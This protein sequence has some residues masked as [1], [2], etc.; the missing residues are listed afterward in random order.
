MEQH[1]EAQEHPC[2]LTTKIGSVFNLVTYIYIFRSSYLSFCCSTASKY[3]QEPWNSSTRLM[4]SKQF[5]SC[6]WMCCVVSKSCSKTTMATKQ[7]REFDI[8][9]DSWS[10]G[11]STIGRPSL[12]MHSSGRVCLVGFGIYSQY[13][14]RTIYINLA[15]FCLSGKAF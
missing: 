5:I 15:W 12:L 8:F 10:I 9:L 11:Y 4:W 13:H 2:I 14:T 1:V 3:M 6:Y 7:N